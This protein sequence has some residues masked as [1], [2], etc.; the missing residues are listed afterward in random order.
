MVCKRLRLDVVFYRSCAATRYMTSSA[1]GHPVTQPAAPSEPSGPEL[2]SSW[3]AGET[4]GAEARLPHSPRVGRVTGRLILLAVLLAAVGLWWADQHQRSQEFSQLIGAAQH[5]QSVVDDSDRRVES[6]IEYASPLLHAAR[7]PPDVRAGLQALVHQA[8]VQAAGS[9][10]AAARATDAVA[11]LPWHSALAASR[12]A[13]VADL[14]AR[15]AYYD[16]FFEPGSDPI[17]TDSSQARVAPLSA[18]A[19]AAFLS[20]A[21]TPAQRSQVALVFAR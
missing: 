18:A 17:T 21:S 7:T 13:Y 8:A 14:E 16:S 2:T 9:L 11:V 4:L 10:R 20:A 12:K 5:G 6:M 3:P 15:A 1:G 19:Q